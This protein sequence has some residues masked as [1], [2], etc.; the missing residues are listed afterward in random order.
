[1]LKMKK[2]KYVACFDERNVPYL[3]DKDLFTI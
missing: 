2:K 1:M 3:D